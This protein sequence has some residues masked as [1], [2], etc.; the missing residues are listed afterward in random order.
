MLCDS[1]EG[2]KYQSSGSDVATKKRTFGK[3]IER[4]RSYQIPDRMGSEAQ[5]E[6][7]G[8]EGCCQENLR[9]VRVEAS[10]QRLTPGG[11]RQQFGE[12]AIL[13]DRC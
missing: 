5:A 6:E 4:Q 11:N 12:V 8:S 10:P 2:E 7:T 13:R 9:Q 1:G 3:V